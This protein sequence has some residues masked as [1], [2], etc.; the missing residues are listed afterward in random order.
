MNE[1]VKSIKEIYWAQ[2]AYFANWH[3]RNRLGV[4]GKRLALRLHA[5]RTPSSNRSAV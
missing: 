4:L 3:T 1:T 2:R 5:W